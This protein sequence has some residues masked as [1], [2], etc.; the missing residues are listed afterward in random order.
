MAEPEWD[1]VTVGLADWEGL[2]VRLAVRELGVGEEVA[3]EG[4]KDAVRV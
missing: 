1:S 2:K 3:P 4:L